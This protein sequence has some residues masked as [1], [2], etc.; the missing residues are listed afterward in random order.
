MLNSDCKKIFTVA[1]TQFMYKRTGKLNELKITSSSNPIPTSGI[2][3]SSYIEAFPETGYVYPI[4]AISSSAL[5]RLVFY[6][7]GILYLENNAGT[8]HISERI[9]CI[10]HWIA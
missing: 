10:I 2:D 7:N 3:I 4:N 6:T 9:N 5:C 8:A 1:N